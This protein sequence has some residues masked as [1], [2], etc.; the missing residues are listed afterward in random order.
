MLAEVFPRNRLE[1]LPEVE[2]RLLVQADALRFRHGRGFELVLSKSTHLIRMPAA[3][4]DPS[5][6]LP[7]LQDGRPSVYSHRPRGR[8]PLR[9]V[10][11][12]RD[13]IAADECAGP[14]DG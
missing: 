1:V 5:S 9:N 12:R 2:R 4:L 14:A 13:L 6:R 10:T 7:A 3:F 8:P 11:L